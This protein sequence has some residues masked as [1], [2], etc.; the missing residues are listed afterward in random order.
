M[1]TNLCFCR[2]FSESLASPQRKTFSRGFGPYGAP[3][4]RNFSP[5]L[6][7][8]TRIPLILFRVTLFRELHNPETKPRAQ[9][10]SA[11]WHVIRYPCCVLVRTAQ[12]LQWCQ[13]P[14]RAL[15]RRFF[16]LRV[17]PNKALTDAVKCSEFLWR[18]VFW[19]YFCNT[20]VWLRLDKSFGAGFQPSVRQPPPC[21]EPH[22]HQSQPL[23]DEPVKC[24]PLLM[25]HLFVCHSPTDVSALTCHVMGVNGLGLSSNFV[26]RQN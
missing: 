12:E 4:E 5:L 19:M 17:W 21:R 6:L 23:T 16:H 15:K 13:I 18:Q 8:F 1:T 10:N 22:K 25:C 3:T 26:F 11:N 9:K 20:H 24:H 7:S 2:Y 14:A